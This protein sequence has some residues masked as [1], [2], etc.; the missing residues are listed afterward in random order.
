MPN[1]QSSGAVELL[2][3]TRCQL[4]EGPL[5]DARRQV[6]FWSDIE[7]GEIFA[8]SDAGQS[9]S[10][11]YRGDPVGGFTLEED[12]ALALFRVNDIARFDP[13][14]GDLKTKAFTD[15]G[16]R[17]FNDVTADPR[18]RVF[19]GTIGKDDLSGGLF[20]FDPDGSSRLLF[21]GTGVSNGMDFSP[22]GRTFYWTCSTTG[23][24]F[25]F[26]Y[27]LESGALSGSRVFYACEPAEGVPDGLCVDDHGNVWSARWEGGCI[28]GHKADDG[29]V[30]T[31][32]NVP[33]ARVTS[34]CFGGGEN[35]RMFITTARTPDEQP[36]GI[37]GAL[38]ATRTGFSGAPVFNSRLFTT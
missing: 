30:F 25:A 4:G 2:A 10:C 1:Q 32:I 35:D 14:S 28:V 26:D 16:M 23:K 11:I 38:F 22:D 29:R 3:P 24:I 8:W 6:L 17:R 33:A 34:C 5:W 7:R 20:R 12:G 19:A 9:H 13:D 36:A 31:S 37:A 27:D 18:G 21:R 15:E